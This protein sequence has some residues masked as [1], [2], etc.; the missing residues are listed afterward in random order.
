[1]QQPGKQASKLLKLIVDSSLPCQTDGTLSQGILPG[2]FSSYRLLKSLLCVSAGY[3]NGLF[4]GKDN[5]LK[6]LLPGSLKY[7]VH[8]SIRHIPSYSKNQAVPPAGIP[9]YGYP[10]S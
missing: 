2:F 4:F 6:A 8:L 1:M 7:T 5:N 9:H 3:D 10:G